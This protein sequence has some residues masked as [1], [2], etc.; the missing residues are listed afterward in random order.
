[1]RNMTEAETA[2]RYV[3]QDGDIQG[4]EYFDNPE[5]CAQFL[6]DYSGVDLLK[7]NLQLTRK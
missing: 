4:K 2:S 7:A 6:R 1:M 5:L 3:G